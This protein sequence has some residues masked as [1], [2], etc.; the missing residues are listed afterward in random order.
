[1]AGARRPPVRVPEH[2]ARSS[3]DVALALAAAS[4]QRLRGCPAPARSLDG[5]RRRRGA[6]CRG[7]RDRGGAR[8]NRRNGTSTGPV[9]LFHFSK[10]GG[11]PTTDLHV[12]QTR[13]PRVPGGRAAVGVADEWHGSFQP[14]R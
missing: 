3:G 8:T 12:G 2:T 9:E 14:G 6:R 11:L 10:C 13:P 7:G 4:C 1:M 5:R